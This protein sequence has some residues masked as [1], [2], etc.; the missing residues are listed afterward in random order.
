MFFSST[1]SHDVDYLVNFEIFR[2]LVQQEFWGRSAFWNIYFCLNL[3]LEILFEF[4]EDFFRIFQDFKSL[5]KLSSL[6][7]TTWTCL[8]VSSTK[9][10]ERSSRKAR[11]F[12]C[13]RCMKTMTLPVESL[14]R[15]FM[16]K[17]GRKFSVHVM[18]KLW[19]AI[20]FIAQCF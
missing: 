9:K 7:R 13:F 16:L 11:K 17:E 19:K 20:Y 5:K 6:Q 18:E 15:F 10:N 8:K 14:F 2:I 12:H 1:H 4:F 3:D